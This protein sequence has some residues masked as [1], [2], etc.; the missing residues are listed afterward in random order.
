MQQRNI[1]LCIV[2]TV[3]TCGLYGL[4]WFVVL[5]DD[6]NELCGEPQATSG[7]LALVFSLVTC[8]LYTLYWAYKMGERICAAK[9]SRGMLA[10]SN[11]G[12]L[13]LVLCLFGVG[14]V[15]YA[16]MQNEVNKMLPGEGVSL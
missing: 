9:L 4:Y 10:D 5:T 11:T 13:Y 3:V 1:A 15:A 2:L 16:L 7:A 6:V 14:I 12:I 8:G